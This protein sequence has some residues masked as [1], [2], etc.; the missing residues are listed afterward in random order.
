MFSPF[1]VR[2]NTVLVQYRHEIFVPTAFSP[3]GD[4]TNDELRA[5]NLRQGSLYK[6][7]IFDKGGRPVYSGENEDFL[8]DGTNSEGSVNDGVY[9]YSLSGQ[10]AEGKQ[11]FKKWVFPSGYLPLIP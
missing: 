1:P 9:Y 8:W 5:V 6:I 10:D 2:S 11:V 7:Y 3:N 4:G